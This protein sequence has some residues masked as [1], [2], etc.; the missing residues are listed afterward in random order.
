MH[1][2]V[3]ITF[4]KGRGVLEETD[5]LKPT[6]CLRFIRLIFPGGHVKLN[7]SRYTT[8]GKKFLNLA[9]KAYDETGDVFPI[10]AECLGFELISLI[11]SGRNLR[12]GQYDQSF[13]SLTDARNISLKF[14]LPSGYKSTKLL[15]SAPDDIIKYMT[16]NDVNYNN[17]NRGLIPEVFHKDQNL[18]EFFK[19]VS[20]SNDRKGKPFIATMEARKYP[21]YMFQWHPGKPLFEWS[22][23]K[24]IRHTREAILI[25]Q[26]FADFF[27]NQAR[28]SDHQFPSTEEEKKALIYNYAPTYTG[29]VVSVLQ[30]YFW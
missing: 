12:F 19:I 20:T 24:D 3:K 18:R 17:H 5:P 27:V 4:L 1:L 28:L 30:M 8:V 9:V 21:I 29:D 13:L 7:M 25:A 23:V 2:S 11:V 16:Q 14:V 15:G 10:W 6:L 26:Y 22:T